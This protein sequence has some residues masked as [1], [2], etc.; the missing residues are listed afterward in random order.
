MATLGK[1]NEATT[2]DTKCRLHRVQNAECRMPAS[3]KRSTKSTEAQRHRGAEPTRAST[4][5]ARPTQAGASH[6]KP[7]YDGIAAGSAQ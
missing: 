3:P 6:H 2:Q 4:G 7:C 1:C 5:Q